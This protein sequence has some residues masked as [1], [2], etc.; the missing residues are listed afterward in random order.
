M[1]LFLNDF[2]NTKVSGGT[3]AQL[4]HPALGKDS[5]VSIRQLVAITGNFGHKLIYGN[6]SRW[7]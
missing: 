5:G 2:D 1:T 7:R 6:I 4:Y 3:V